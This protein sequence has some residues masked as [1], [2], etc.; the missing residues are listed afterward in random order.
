MKNSS[1]KA[2]KFCKEVEGKVLYVGKKV[3]YVIVRKGRKV[4]YVRPREKIIRASNKNS[5]RV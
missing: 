3:L 4:L 2:T 5:S 1:R